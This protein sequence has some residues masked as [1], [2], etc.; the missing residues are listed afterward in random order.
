MSTE[1]KGSSAVED[2]PS[3]T[4]AGGDA[5][6]EAVATTTSEPEA[7]EATLEIPEKGFSILPPS[8]EGDTPSATG[9]ALVR[10]PTSS[11][12]ATDVDVQLTLMDGD[13]GVIS[14]SSSTISALL[15]DSVAV[16]S[17][18]ED[19]VAEVADVKVQAR[20]GG[21]EEPEGPI[22]KLTVSGINIRQ[23]EYGGADVSGVVAS[24]SGQ[25]L[26]DVEVGVVFRDES[27]TAVAGTFTYVDFVP[28]NGD[29][30]FTLST[31]NEIP[32]GWTAEGHA[33][34]S[35]LTLLGE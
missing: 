32:E 11:Q 27:D 31:M 26:E 16:V 1:D 29:I 23:D 5:E 25:D 19:D 7:E 28:A 14:S 20:P 17:M 12:I 8:Y 35:F 34:V 21:W 2:S 30:P 24:T 15:P 33:T 3:T 4:A 10:N 9:V 22:G 6:Q 18:V 13:G